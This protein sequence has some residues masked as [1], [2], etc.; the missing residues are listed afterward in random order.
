LP[1]PPP[2]PQWGPRASVYIS[3]TPAYIYNHCACM[4]MHICGGCWP[5][6]TF[7]IIPKTNNPAITNDYASSIFDTNP[8]IPET[9]EKNIIDDMC[10]AFC[11]FCPL[12][13]RFLYN[14]VSVHYHPGIP[15][16]F[17]HLDVHVLIATT[18]LIINKSLNWRCI[19]YW[20]C[21]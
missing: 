8:R 21:P 10:F 1:P 14:Y 20:R 6:V 19:Y 18:T 7:V 16:L 12:P 3:N 11:A 4:L 9:T 15:K 17:I 2:L 13:R 5:S